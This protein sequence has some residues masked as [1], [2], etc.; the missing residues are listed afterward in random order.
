[1]KELKTYTRKLIQERNLGDGAKITAEDSNFIKYQN[2][3][4]EEV[5]LPVFY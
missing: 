1:M 3:K 5:I 2:K 4:Q